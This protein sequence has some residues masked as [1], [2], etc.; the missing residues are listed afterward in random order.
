MMVASTDFEKAYGFL[1][2]HLLPH[3][4][5]SQLRLSFKNCSFFMNEITVLEI[6]HE[7]GVGST[8]KPSRICKIKDYPVPKDK[9][10]LREFLGTIGI[11]RKWAKNFAEISWPLTGLTGDV[12]WRWGEAEQVAFDLLKGFC[13]KVLTLNRWRLRL[14]VLI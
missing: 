10:G 11:T 8:I 2:D 9:T 12:T 7:A 5:W 14:P 6:V 4:L 13:S 1:E 3:F